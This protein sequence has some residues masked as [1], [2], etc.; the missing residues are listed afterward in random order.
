MKVLYDIREMIEDEM[1][2][3]CKQDSLTGTD[4]EELYKMVD[5]VKD[6]STV[7]AMEQADFG[8]GYSGAY[9]YSYEMDYPMST[10]GRSRD[11]MGRYSGRGGSSY[12]GRSYARESSYDDYSGHSKEQ[13]IEKLKVMMR[14][15][16][17][18]EERESYRRAIE[19]L[20]RS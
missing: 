9:G 7:E 1:K 10:R 15:A 12:E 18:E 11:S 8:D 17:N 3:I 19:A 20:N 4:L 5:I 16:R 6:I 13:M 2:K 14:E